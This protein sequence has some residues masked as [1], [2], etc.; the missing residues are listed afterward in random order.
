MSYFNNFA[1]N[2]NTPY[3]CN[4]ENNLKD[5]L[6][7]LGK[8]KRIKE[9]NNAYIIDIEVN[10]NKYTILSLKFD[11]TLYSK[12]KKNKCYIFEIYEYFP[13]KIVGDIGYI[14]CSIGD[15]TV[16]FK[17]DTKTGMIVTSPNLF[18]LYYTP[19][20]NITYE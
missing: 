14:R 1:T 5:S 18:G 19:P 11:T 12:I 15:V 3:N 16:E 20:A 13:Y 6:R 7:V 10:N 4:P 8:V 2:Y 17:G 9:N